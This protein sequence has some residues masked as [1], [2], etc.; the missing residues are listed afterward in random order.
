MLLLVSA[1][2]RLEQSIGRIK[3][4]G[5]WGLLV[6]IT[7]CQQTV[8]LE[9]LRKTETIRNP[10]EW[11]KTN[12]IVAFI[13]LSKEG[14]HEFPGGPVVRTHAFTA[15]AWI[16]SLVLE[17]RSHMPRCSK[18]KKTKNKQTNKQTKKQGLHKKIKPWSS[19]RHLFYLMSF[20]LSSSSSMILP[21]YH[22]WRNWD[23]S[24]WNHFLGYTV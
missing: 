5:W 18:K 17:L 14:V 8:E 3:A 12:Y 16:Q 22:L 20:L 9:H 2:T 21:N 7:F 4:H 23:N 11:G 24:H 15:G 6:P 13:C 10:N 1:E 19:K